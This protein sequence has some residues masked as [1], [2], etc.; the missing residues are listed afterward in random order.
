M[1]KRWI[2]Y[3]ALAAASL[4]LSACI[5]TGGGGPASG[6]KS[7][8]PFLFQNRGVAHA[9]AVKQVDAASYN[10][11]LGDRYW[12]QPGEFFFFKQVGVMVGNN[13]FRASRDGGAFWVTFGHAPQGETNGLNFFQGG[14]GLN[15]SEVVAIPPGQSRTYTA[16]EAVM[17]ITTPG[18]SARED[19]I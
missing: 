9:P 3:G 6:Q 8:G 18:D 12:P 17:S 19:E 7:D 16:G 11:V 10:A 5:A 4:G 1:T 15:H 13:G 2:R 14:S